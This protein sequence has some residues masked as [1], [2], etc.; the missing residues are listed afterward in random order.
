[1]VF[2]LETPS[3]YENLPSVGNGFPGIFDIESILK[4]WPVSFFCLDGGSLHSGNR[5]HQE[6]TIVHMKEDKASC[7]A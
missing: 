4:L 2:G 7:Q 1:M 3:D 5:T 6:N